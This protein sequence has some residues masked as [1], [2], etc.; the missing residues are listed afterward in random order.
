MRYQR[1]VR[2][3]D[4]PNCGVVNSA[5]M[6]SSVWG[7]NYSCCSD[8]CGLEFKVKLNNFYRTRK[9]ITLKEKIELF[10]AKLVVFKAEYLHGLISRGK[11]SS[12]TASSS[13]GK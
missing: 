10:E 7:H 8:D 13:E 11:L 1:P 5:Y 6:G 9:A 2:L 4:C 3:D 12:D